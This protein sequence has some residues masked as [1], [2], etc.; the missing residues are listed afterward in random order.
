MGTGSGLPVFLHF[1]ILPYSLE[2]GATMGKFS[3]LPHLD[4]MTFGFPVV[5]LYGGTGSSSVTN[6]SG[7]GMTINVAYDTSVASAPTGFTDVV[8]Q[9]V[10]YL[11]SQFSDPITVNIAVGYGEAGGSNLPG[12]ALGASSTYLSRFSYSAIKNALAADAKTTADSSA[13]ASL[14]ATD[15]TGGNWWVTTAEAKAIGLMGASSSI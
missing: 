4:W 6:L 7:T 12:N 11:E 14:P 10:Q 13:V 3:S 1:R 5:V 8:N 15:P 2:S 9:V